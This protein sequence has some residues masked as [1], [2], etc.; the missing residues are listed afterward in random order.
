MYCVPPIDAITNKKSTINHGMPPGPRG[1]S[2]DGPRKRFGGRC[3]RRTCKVVDDRDGRRR[4]MRGHSSAS[5]PRRW[6]R[7]RR[8]GGGRGVVHRARR[9]MTTTIGR[10]RRDDDPRPRRQRPSSCLRLLRLL[11]PP[12]DS[13]DSTSSSSLGEVD[14]NLVPGMPSHPPPR[15]RRRRGTGRTS[16]PH[17]PWR[18]R[19]HRGRG[20]SRTYGRA[21]RCSC[22][23]RRRGG[24]S[25]GEKE[26]G[27]ERHGTEGEGGGGGER[28]GGTRKKKPS[29]GGAAYRAAGRG[30][31]NCGKLRDGGVG[32][33]DYADDDG[34]GEDDD[35]DDDD[36]VGDRNDVR[37]HALI[38]LLP[39]NGRVTNRDAQR[40]RVRRREARRCWRRWDLTINM[41]WGERVGGGKT[42]KTTTEE[43]ETLRG[44]RSGGN[45]GR[46]RTTAIIAG[47][48]VVSSFAWMLR[49][50]RQSFR[51]CHTK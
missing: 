49:L 43:G 34:F 23:R 45:G 3:R 13:D 11:P 22:S 28:N 36:D 39:R 41:M 48:E 19:W 24:G 50:T 44:Q 29:E 2:R 4:Q 1:S 18:G 42:A 46:G 26:E 37:R 14:V 33:N 40:A 51:I 20:G 32:G 16:A 15:G 17:P 6:S 21:T 35:D 27:S 10:H 9:P 8:L 12:S 5:L 30:G 31:A 47:G 25:D 38:A 7:Q